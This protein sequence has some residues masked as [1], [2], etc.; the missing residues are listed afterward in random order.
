MMNKI[1]RLGRNLMKKSMKPNSSV[2][3]IQ[4]QHTAILNHRFFSDSTK[5][6]VETPSQESTNENSNAEA[7]NEQEAFFEE[8]EIVK[9]ASENFQFQ[10]ETSKLLHI[11]AKSLY[12]DKDVFIREL[13]SNASDSIEKVRYLVMSG[14]SQS[15]SPLQVNLICN[16]EKRQLIIQDTGIGMNKDDLINHLGTIASSGSQKFIDA[17]KSNNSNSRDLE[18]SIIGQFGVG[19]YSAFIVA[20]TVEVI[21]KKENEDAYVWVSDGNGTFEISSAQNFHL[22]HGTKIILHLKPEFA[23]YTR[24]S[25]I[26]T[27]IEKYSNFIKHPIFVNNEKINLV[28]ALW[29]R[30]KREVSEEEY[31]NFYE[32]LSKSKQVYRW[33][34]HFQTDVPMVIKSLIYFPMQNQEMFGFNSSE[35]GL[36]LYSKKVLIKPNCRELI[37]NY[38]RFVKGIVDCEDIPLNISRENYQD[39]N[40]IHKLKS[41][42]TKKI[43]R[44]LEHES[45]NNP[46]EYIKW[47]KDF[48]IYIKEGVHTDTE[49]S[50]ILLSLIRYDS[51]FADNVT[52][53]TYIEKM[54]PNHKSI[55]YFFAP[56]KD[57]AS[58][59]PYMENFL[60]NDI[61]VLYININAE[62]MIF[63]Q[64]NEYKKFPFVNVESADAVIANDLLKEKN[65]IEIGTEKL[66]AEDVQMFT[67][68]VKNELQPVVKEVISSKRLTDSPALVTSEMTSGMR[69]IMAM[70][71][72]THSMDHSKNLTL[73][74][75]PNHPIIVNLN[76]LR[77]KNLKQANS[78]LK[79]L[80]DICLMSAGM[81]FDQ[82]NFIKRVNDN[83]LQNMHLNLE[84]KDAHVELE[85]SHTENTGMGV[86]NEALKHSKRMTSVK[87]EEKEMEFEINEKGEPVVKN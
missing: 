62:E 60:K 76:K 48:H 69:Q 52:L 43:L 9:G 23:N 4:T 5:P 65:E 72:S 86:L 36:S 54:K 66:E 2:N 68:W 26:K 42:V 81:S 41:V 38:L 45:K 33:K 16:E 80:L 82:K 35:T 39:S 77:K 7:K 67:L 74:I 17:L 1:T 78:N 30:D 73:E 75:N 37:P 47:Y 57:M 83:M 50:E 3:Q 71:D 59:S 61:P 24:P 6:I 12:T 21:S 70:M 55:Y 8:E 20:D 53:D 63:R 49:N 19:F 56:Q 14:N 44:T 28:S 58:H 11:V 18:D 22:E 87:T 29:A 40:L 84:K 13:L 51:T 31:K 10:T 79:Q 25:E 46:E 15:S 85:N 27:I 64:M 32:L 34:L